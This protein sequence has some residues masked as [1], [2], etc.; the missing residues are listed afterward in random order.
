MIFD[1]EEMLALLADF[2]EKYPL[3]VDYGGEYI[4]E[5]DNAK[6]DAVQLVCYIFDNM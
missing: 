4:M 3:V 5:N 1:K 6:A 2:I